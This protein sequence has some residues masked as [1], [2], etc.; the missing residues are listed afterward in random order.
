MDWRVHVVDGEID[1]GLY[2]KLGLLGDRPMVTYYDW[3]SKSL[4]FALAQT[5][6]PT[7]AAD[8]NVHF[9]NAE[10][11]VCLY[12]SLISYDNRPVMSY[13]GNGDL[14][15]ARALTDNPLEATD[16]QILPVDD[17]GAAGNYSSLVFVNDRPAIA[18]YGNPG[19]MFASRQ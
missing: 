18:Y 16:W 7:G 12:P 3:S 8:W 2:S 9:V 1:V 17:S 6:N 10:G 13:Y 15:Y 4:K 14:Y 11:N 19:L 5:A